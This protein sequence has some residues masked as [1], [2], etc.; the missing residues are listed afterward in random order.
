MKIILILLSLFITAC[1]QK[2]PP[3]RA[4]TPLPSAIDPPDSALEAPLA[5]FI[6]NQNA[7]THSEWD[8]ARVDLNDDGRRDAIIFFK[9]PHS[10]WCGW[11]GCGMLVL[12]ASN[13]SFIPV[14]TINNVRGPIYVSSQKTK[15]WR[16]I[17]IRVTGTNFP[18]KNIVMAF[19]GVT[20]PNSPLLGADLEVPLSALN[21]Q[22]FFR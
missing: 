5:A 19:D 18:D 11:D 12:R 21:T 13:N 22:R 6:Q 15:N 7:P 17:I 8:V 10:Y 16:D 20:Y 3:P 1:G 2:T 14:T 4:F 9:T